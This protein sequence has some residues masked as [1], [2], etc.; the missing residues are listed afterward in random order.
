M[1]DFFSLFFLHFLIF[2]KMFLWLLYSEKIIQ[3]LLQNF[4]VRVQSR[5]LPEAIHQTTNCYLPR[6]GLN[7]QKQFDQLNKLL[8]SCWLVTGCLMS[9]NGHFGHRQ[10]SAGW[11][12]RAQEKQRTSH[13]KGQPTRSFSLARWAGGPEFSESPV[14]PPWALL[15]ITHKPSHTQPQKH[16]HDGPS[17][18][19]KWGQLQVPGAG[20]DRCRRPLSEVSLSGPRPGQQD[21]AAG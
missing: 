3:K 14:P 9:L 15:Q 1:G 8:V 16:G 5:D 17:S 21:Q 7:K 20:L 12:A 13:R 11:C 2:N 19:D 18:K 10:Q 4:Y 6:R